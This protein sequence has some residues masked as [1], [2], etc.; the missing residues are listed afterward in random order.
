MTEL[1]TDKD[2]PEV[3]QDQ[4]DHIHAIHDAAAKMQN[5]VSDLL[6]VPT[7]KEKEES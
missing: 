1:L 7:I 5:L 2:F 6:A 3:R 4:N